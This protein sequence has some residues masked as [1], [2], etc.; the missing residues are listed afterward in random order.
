MS[1]ALP[2]VGVQSTAEQLLHTTTL[3]EWL[4]TV[5]LQ[6]NIHGFS[7]VRRNQSLWLT[8]WNAHSAQRRKCIAQEN[9]GASDIGKAYI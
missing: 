7:W 9:S 2:P 3:W 4:N 1:L 5:V 6:D 8:K